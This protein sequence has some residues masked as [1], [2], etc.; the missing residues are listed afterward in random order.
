MSGQETT[1]QQFLEDELGKILAQGAGTF[2]GAMRPA[3]SRC[4]EKRMELVLSFPALDWERNGLGMLHGGV[5]SAMTDF[6]MSLGVQYFA[7]SPIPPT[8]SYTMNYIRPVPVGG[9]VLVACRVTSAGRRVGTAWCEALIADTG[10]RA[11]TAT[12]TYSTARPG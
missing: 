12:G 9:E 2:N 10:K 7:R 8:I 5:L 4:D 3:F 11:A 6:T 1:L